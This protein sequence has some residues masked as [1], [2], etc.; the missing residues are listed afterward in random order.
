MWA[1]ITHSNK[2]RQTSGFPFTQ[3]SLSLWIFT[4][5]IFCHFGDHISD[6]PRLVL[7]DKQEQEIPLGSGFAT[8]LILFVVWKEKKIILVQRGE[9]HIAIY[10]FT[11]YCPDPFSPITYHMLLI[12]AD[13]FWIVSYIQY[14]PFSCVMAWEMSDLNAIEAEQYAKAD[15]WSFASKETNQSGGVVCIILLTIDY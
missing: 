6:K 3:V 10:Y 12:A 7:V 1:F 5:Y 4:R 11:V 2:A 13:T 8:L 15:G 9:S 14:H